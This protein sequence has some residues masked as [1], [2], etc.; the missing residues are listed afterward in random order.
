[1]TK[2]CELRQSGN[3]GQPV[4]TSLNGVVRALADTSPVR[5]DMRWSIFWD[6]GNGILPVPLAIEPVGQLP[7]LANDK[8]ENIGMPSY[9]WEQ[10]ERKKGGIR[11]QVEAVA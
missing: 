11:I 9:R 5:A 7:E 8:L 3:A 1:M 6:N 4:Q 2:C 10:A